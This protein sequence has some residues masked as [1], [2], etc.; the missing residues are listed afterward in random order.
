MKLLTD[1]TTAFDPFMGQRLFLRWKYADLPGG[2]EERVVN[3]EL[4][5]VGGQVAQAIRDRC[6]YL[7]YDRRLVPDDFDIARP[8][9][10]S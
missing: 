3:E 9:P 6:H 5:L 8:P 7:I 4:Q 10:E 1:L 2:V